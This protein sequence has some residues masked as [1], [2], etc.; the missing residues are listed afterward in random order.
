MRPTQDVLIQYSDSTVLLG[1]SLGHDASAALLRGN[2]ELLYASLEE[3]FS[4]K[5]HDDAFPRQ[6]LEAGLTQCGLTFDDVSAVYVSCKPLLVIWRLFRFSLFFYPL[7]YPFFFSEL[8]AFIARLWQMRAYF[9]AV[10][11]QGK[12][13]YT[14]HHLAHASHFFLSPFSQALVVVADG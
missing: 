1:L 9:Q 12:I 3:R 5:K 13:Y 2:G 8:S 11:W 4:Q 7:S 10:N 6:S 14:E